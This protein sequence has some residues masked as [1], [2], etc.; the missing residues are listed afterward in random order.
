MCVSESCVYPVYMFAETLLTCRV[1]MVR[2]TGR[3]LQGSGRQ[4]GQRCGLWW[5]LWSFC[6]AP[7]ETLWLR[8]VKIGMQAWL[9]VS[10]E[11]CLPVTDVNNWNWNVNAHWNKPL[12]LWDPRA[13]CVLLEVRGTMFV[14]MLT[15]SWITSGKKN[16]RALFSSDTTVVIVLGLNF[17]F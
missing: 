13:L 3:L 10:I 16:A 11:R 9:M 6:D 4:R 14:T 15:Y 7:E 2:M 1:P 12:F 5:V 17:S 8:Y